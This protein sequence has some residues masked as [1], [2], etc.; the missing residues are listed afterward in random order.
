MGLFTI[1]SREVRWT[2]TIPAYC[3]W[4]VLCKFESSSFV[5]LPVDAQFLYLVDCF[6]QVRNFCWVD[7]QELFTN[8]GFFLARLSEKVYYRAVLP[9]QALHTDTLCRHSGPPDAHLCGP[10]QS[11]SYHTLDVSAH[12][13]VGLLTLSCKADGYPFQG[14]LRLHIQ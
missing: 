13:W 8:L 11:D 4:F 14:S 3:W 10:H 12:P 6:R 2:L 5:R 9:L 7:L 1:S